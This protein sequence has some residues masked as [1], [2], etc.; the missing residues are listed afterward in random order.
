MVNLLQNLSVSYDIILSEFSVC[1][2]K[3]LIL[4]L[5]AMCCP[6]PLSLE[7]FCKINNTNIDILLFEISYYE[8]FIIGPFSSTNA[9]R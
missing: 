5:D 3:S 9:C 7:I 2:N 4:I 8:I 1:Q 6:N